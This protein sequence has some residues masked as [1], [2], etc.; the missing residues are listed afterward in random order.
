LSPA[1]GGFAHRLPPGL[2]PSPDRLF[3]P[4]NKF[5]DTPLLHSA[6]DLSDSTDAAIRSRRGLIL[7]ITM[8][9]WVAYAA[10]NGNENYPHFISWALVVSGGVE[11]DPQ[12]KIFVHHCG[13]R[14]HPV[15]GGVKLPQS[16]ANRTMLGGDIDSHERL[17][18][19]DS[20]R[21]ICASQILLL[22]YLLTIVVTSNTL[23]PEG[24]ETVPVC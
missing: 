20:N 21:T 11:A 2:C 13:S 16:P 9:C 5:L 22:T 3:C 24:Q 7:Y 19:K 23:Y 12:T 10:L 15:G 4:H 1:S 18:V 14:P 17:L 8:R 6:A